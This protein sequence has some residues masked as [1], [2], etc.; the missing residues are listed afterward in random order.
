MS[1]FLPSVIFS[2]FAQNKEW[3]GGGGGG[4]FNGK[5][6]KPGGPSHIVFLQIGFASS[7]LAASNTFL[8]NLGSQELGKAIQIVCPVY[9][10][11]G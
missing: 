10:I 8:T 1:A 4:G 2:F 9:A 11:T 3:G 7:I 5:T 6:L